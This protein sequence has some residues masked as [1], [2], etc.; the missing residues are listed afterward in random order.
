MERLM[1]REGPGIVIW[2]GVRLSR[3]VASRECD[4]V[5]DGTGIV[6]GGVQSARES[7]TESSQYWGLGRQAQ[8]K[9]LRQIC[10]LT[11]IALHT[12]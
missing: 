12:I 2:T 1:Q 10:I 9:Q 8:H 7:H 6:E 3:P 11:E 4:D 5:R